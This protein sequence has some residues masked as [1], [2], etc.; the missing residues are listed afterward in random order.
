MSAKDIFHEA[1]KHAL[2]KD[3]WQIT[4]DP[5]FLRFGGLDMYIDLGAEKILAA[6]R[7]EEKIAVEVKSFVS[8]SA[9][10]EFSTALG[11]FLKYQLALE[12]EQP[13][14]LLYLAVPFDTYRS[15]FT[16][17]LP[18]LLIQRYQVRLIIFDPEEEIIVKWQK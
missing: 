12:E 10:T 7:E 18:S 6:E 5:L 16:L 14:R 8:P 9:T 2:Q 1:V 3:A 17:E 15:F 4:H 11:Q 13:Q